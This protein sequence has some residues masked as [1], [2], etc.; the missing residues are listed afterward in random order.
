MPD[1][2]DRKSDE[3]VRVDAVAAAYRRTLLDAENLHAHAVAARRQQ[4]AGGVPVS[5]TSGRPL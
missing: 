1:A 3:G 5:H 4:P 2:L